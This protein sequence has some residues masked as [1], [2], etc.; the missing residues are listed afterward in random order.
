M[1]LVEQ[2]SIPHLSHLRPPGSIFKGSC[3][4][5]SHVTFLYARVSH[6]PLS[7]Q[8][9]TRKML[10]FNALP[11]DFKLILAKMSRFIY[12]HTPFGMNSRFWLV[13]SS[14]RPD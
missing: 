14:S 8:R 12:V 9:P 1:S 3:N 7:S 13:K 6:F 5:Y 10:F 2:F 4:I 11:S